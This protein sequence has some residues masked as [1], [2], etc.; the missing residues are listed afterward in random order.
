MFG[1]WKPTTKALMG[2]FLLHLKGLQKKLMIRR[3]RQTLLKPRCG[4]GEANQVN[5][6][7][8]EQSYERISNHAN[9]LDKE[10]LQKFLCEAEFEINN[11]HLSTSDFDRNNYHAWQLR[12]YRS[13]LGKFIRNG[14]I[15]KMS[16]CRR[17]V[18][19]LYR[20]EGFFQQ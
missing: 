3:S 10:S 11:R 20:C 8:H 14:V 5:K 19:E 18:Y 9:H 12:V 15:I 1:K 7:H 2:I 13:L 16:Y 17:S 6:K 4:Q